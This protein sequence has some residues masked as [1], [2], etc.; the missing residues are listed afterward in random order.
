MGLVSVRRLPTLVVAFC[1]LPLLGCGHL[2]LLPGGEA[3]LTPHAFELTYRDV[4][5]D[6][7]RGPRLHGWY[8]PAGNDGVTGTVLFLHGN[9]GNISNHL[10]SVAWLP[11]R[12][13][14]VLLIDYRGYG[15]SQGQASLP[16]VAVDVRRALT[17]LAKREGEGVPL[18]VF[19]QSLGGGLAPY[20][21][22]GSAQRERVRAVVLDSAFSGFRR[23]AREKLDAFWLTWPF[24][25]PLSWTVTDDY[26]AIRYIA[27]LHP[28]PV[29]IIHGEADRVVPVEHAR[30]L[31]A[32]A[33]GPKSLWLVPGAGHIQ[34]LWS[35][36]L[37]KRLAEHLRDKLGGG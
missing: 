2:F 33:Q 36:S 14:N 9:A 26:S 7:G 13:F 17:Y 28:I 35:S 11:G 8:L 5:I 34:S 16:G 22:A 6:D 31:Y 12:G 23:I 15:A 19:G 29:L 30:T 32:H 24:Q 20:A 21:V 18:A 25:V 1:L 10:L 3:T 4:H 37:R 27:D